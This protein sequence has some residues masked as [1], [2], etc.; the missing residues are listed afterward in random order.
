M[1]LLANSI[2]LQPL[3]AYNGWNTADNAVGYAIAQ[4]LI[5]RDMSS[6][7]RSRLLR[8]RLIDD[9][10]YQSNARRSISNELE[11]HNR[12]DLKYDLATEEKNILQQITADCQ[13]MANSY[14]ITRAL[15]SPSPSLGSVYSR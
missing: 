14:S 9:W 6:E 2:N 4:G 13:S 8:Q 1:S 12:E 11:K 3:A 15:N 10:F 7:A 5:A